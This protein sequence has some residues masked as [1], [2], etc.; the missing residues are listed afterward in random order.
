MIIILP[1][2]MSLLSALL[3][4]VVLILLFGYLNYNIQLATIYSL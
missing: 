2:K 3:I 1:D 4:I